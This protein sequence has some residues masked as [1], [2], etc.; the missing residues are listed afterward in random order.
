MRRILTSSSEHALER[1]DADVSLA[2]PKV[3]ER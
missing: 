2:V 3:G 1:F